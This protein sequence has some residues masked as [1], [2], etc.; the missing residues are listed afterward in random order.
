VSLK[1][2]LGT[3]GVLLAWNISAATLPEITIQDTLVFPE[4]LT[5]AADGT[6]FTGSWKGM[7]YRALPHQTTATAWITPSPDNGLLSILGVLADDRRGVLW[8]CSVPAPDRDPPAPGTTALM[9]FDLKTGVQ[10]L[11][12][13]FPGPAGVCNDITLAKDGTAY[14]SDTPNG[15]IFRVRPRSTELELF[16][17]DPQFKGIDGIAFSGKGILYINS[18]TTNKLWRIDIGPDGKMSTV[19][20]LTP[21]QP[22]RGADGFRLLAGNRFLLAENAARNIDAVDIEGNQAKVTVL[23]G[24]LKTPTSAI[25][26][27]NTIYAVERKIEYVRNPALKGQDP[28]PFTVLALPLPK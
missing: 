19:T 16:A 3:A 20:E 12:L 5:A 13:P 23:K 4:S 18:V 15:R 21:S 6:L 10:K 25:R 26:V 9:A 11:N 22:L 27:K 7:V 2:L 14:I 28:G 24:G 8:V 1:I 17:E